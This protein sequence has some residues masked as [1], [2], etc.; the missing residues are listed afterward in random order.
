MA[1]AS[2][3]NCVSDG[4]KKLHFPENIRRNFHFSSA[5]RCANIRLS[6]YQKFD[7]LDYSRAKLDYHE[8]CHLCSFAENL[9]FLRFEIF[10]KYLIFETPWE[11][12]E[13]K[14]RSVVKLKVLRKGSSV[15]R[16]FIFSFKEG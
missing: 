7:F 12:Q 9:I 2:R 3:S 4:A 6:V 14:K 8:R 1:T 11:E 13:E 10:K 16:F 15:L 5:K